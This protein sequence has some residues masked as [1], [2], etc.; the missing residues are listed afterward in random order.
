MVKA[1]KDT[2]MKNNLNNLKKKTLSLW[3]WFMSQSNFKKFLLVGVIIVG[4]YLLKP[5]SDKDAISYQTQSA[6]IGEVVEVVSETGEIMSSGKTEVSSTITG[7]VT[8]VYV[9]NGDQVKKGQSLF[10]VES[11][12]TDQER[13]KAYSSY[14]AAKNSLEAAQRNKQT[15]ESDMW[16]AHEEFEADAL[17]TELSVDDPIFIQ[18][19]RNWQAAEA[20][21][22]DQD[23]VISQAQ[24]AVNSAWY[25][26]QSTIDGV[27]KAP[28]SGTIANMSMSVGQQ[29]D[30]ADN[31]LLI[32]SGGQTWVKLAVSESD[33][34]TVQPG[35]LATVSVD[36]IK[37]SSYEAV[38]K[39][40]DDYG[41]ESSGVVTYNIFLV[42]T[43]A[44]AEVKPG[45]TV[46]VD[47]TTQSKS[48]ALIVPNAAIKPYQGSKAVQIL[49]K[50]TGKPIYIP[51]EIGIQGNTYTEITSGLT[52]GKDVI[53]GQSTGKSESSKSQG[54][55]FPVPG[56]GK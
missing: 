38:V 52:E 15:Y 12:A 2:N 29:V 48:D 14:L 56:G 21:Y 39:R 32:S 19:D 3:G 47:I 27:V 33:V 30:A 5:Q 10:K 17:D 44:P 35:Q 22:L 25:E 43:S 51:V 34:I 49:S 7:I 4:L 9:E 45:M 8:E 23:N 26:Y 37:N 6:Q 20:K 53:I 46:Q 55:I 1:Q 11:S 42:L 24:A 18:T 16:K 41:T 36:A 50:N 54:G 31:A 13:T 28:I 40:V